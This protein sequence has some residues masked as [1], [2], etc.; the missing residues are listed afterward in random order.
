MNRELSLSWARR[1]RIVF[2]VSSFDSRWRAEKD[3]VKLGI[4]RRKESR[5]CGRRCIA[6]R[7]KISG[8]RSFDDAIDKG[9]QAGQRPSVQAVDF[10][11]MGS[12]SKEDIIIPTVMGA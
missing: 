4:A 1:C 3:R 10:E 8:G 2:L 11:T 5:S 6:I 7:S 9:S 12:M